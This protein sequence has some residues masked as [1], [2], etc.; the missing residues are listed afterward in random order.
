MELDRDL[1]R[2][3]LSMSMSAGVA[4]AEDEDPTVGSV[5]VAT[6]EEPDDDSVIPVARHVID[7]MDEALATRGR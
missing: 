4:L 7:A 2:R 5:L 6:A 3:M 1:I